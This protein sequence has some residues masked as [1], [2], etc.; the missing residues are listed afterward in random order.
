MANIP[1]W[2]KAVKENATSKYGKGLSVKEVSGKY[3]LYK[4]SSKRIPGV[5]NPKVTETYI[6]AVTPDGLVLKERGLSKAN[7]DVYE[8]GFSHVLLSICP[9]GWKKA[10]KADWMPVLFTI[11]QR[12]SPNS[13]LL[14]DYKM[15]DVSNRN[16]NLQ[17]RNLWDALP[18]DTRT[19]LEPL[20]RVYQLVYP[21]RVVM[22]NISE[23]Q[24]KIAMEFG[25]DLEGDFE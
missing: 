15:P 18:G 8:Y 21:D 16:I 6:G 14:R 7:V 11:I 9:P 12:E 2:V 22:A 13:Y 23:S 4:R 1:D 20:M 19:R 3:Y 24:K 25:V 17:T 5:K 10:L